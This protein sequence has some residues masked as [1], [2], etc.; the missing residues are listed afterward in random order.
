[1]KKIVGSALLVIAVTAAAYAAT[2]PP[3]PLPQRCGLTS[4]KPCQGQRPFPPLR[5]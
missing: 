3:V 1:M 4:P 2:R 5:R